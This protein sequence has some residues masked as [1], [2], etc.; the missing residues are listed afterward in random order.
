MER[1]R[2]HF[3]VLVKDRAVAVAGEFSRLSSLPPK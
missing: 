1:S 3:Y 2:P